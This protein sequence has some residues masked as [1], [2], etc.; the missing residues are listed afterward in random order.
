M[1]ALTVNEMNAVSGGV[2]SPVTIVKIGLAVFEFINSLSADAEE[3]TAEA[4]NGAK[5]T[6]KGKGAARATANGTT[7]SCGGG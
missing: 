3:S 7:A 6:C 1:R 4:A 5:V 2:L